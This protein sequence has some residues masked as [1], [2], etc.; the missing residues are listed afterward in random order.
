MNA[1]TDLD[2]AATATAHA[3]EAI[4]NAYGALA[5]CNPLAAQAIMPEI[6]VA[7]AIADRFRILADIAREADDA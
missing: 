1:I 6:G 4:R 2:A 5:R 3:A 7:A